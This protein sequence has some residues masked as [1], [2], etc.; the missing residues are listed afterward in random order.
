[1]AQAQQEQECFAPSSQI[2]DTVYTAPF[3]GTC[4]ITATSPD[5]TLE[6]PQH[7]M[8]NIDS[9]HDYSYENTA[10]EP[11]HIFKKELFPEKLKMKKKYWC[12]WGVSCQS[13]KE[14]NTKDQRW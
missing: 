5:T 13:Y 3:D 9:C 14:Q 8:V 6:S 1:M 7:S 11:E 12:L 2:N 10:K 4:S